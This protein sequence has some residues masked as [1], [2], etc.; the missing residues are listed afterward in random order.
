MQISPIY[1]SSSSCDGAPTYWWLPPPPRWLKLNFDGAFNNFTQQA[2]IGGV[3]RH[4]SGN[5]TSAYSG[6]IHADHPLETELIALQRGL[7]RCHELQ[8]SNVQVEGNCLALITS[9]QNSG[10]LTWDMIGSGSE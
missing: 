8:L 4:S 7:V 6:E 9:I 3:I 2:R 1:A 5:M 10:Q